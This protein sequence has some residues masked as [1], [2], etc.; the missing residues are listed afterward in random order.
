MVVN[1]AT[2]RHDVDHRKVGWCWGRCMGGHGA[3][4]CESGGASGWKR[5]TK[6]KGRER[7]KW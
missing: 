2:R 7:D 1:G 6:I 4:G 3:R 5:L